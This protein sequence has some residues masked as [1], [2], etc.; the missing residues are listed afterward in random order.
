MFCDICRRHDRSGSFSVASTNFKLEA[1]KA[2]K[3]RLKQSLAGKLT[4]ATKLC[5]GLVNI[6]NH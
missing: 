2:K 4:W 6:R 3:G 1:M 5:F